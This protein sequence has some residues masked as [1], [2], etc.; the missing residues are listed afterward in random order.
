MRAALGDFT[1]CVPLAFSAN[2][3]GLIAGSI[4]RH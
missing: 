2:S 1:P 4:A 3:T